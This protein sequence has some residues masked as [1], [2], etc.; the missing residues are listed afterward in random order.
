MTVAY[1]VYSGNGKG[2]IYISNYPTMK[3]VHITFKKVR[4]DLII[5]EEELE[6]HSLIH[7][8]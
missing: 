1:C 3:R 4:E 6:E 8:L 7:S 5:E 2:G